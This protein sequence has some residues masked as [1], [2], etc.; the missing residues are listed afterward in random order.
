MTEDREE[1]TLDL[2]V[3]TLEVRPQQEIAVERI[4]LQKCLI[5]PDLNGVNVNKIAYLVIYSVCHSLLKTAPIQ[6]AV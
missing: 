3:W 4:T 6:H 2:T 1:T 5:E